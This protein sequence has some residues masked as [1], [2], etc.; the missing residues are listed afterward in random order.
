MHT[1][2]DFLDAKKNMNIVSQLNDFSA[3]RIAWID[4]LRGLALLMVIVANYFPLLG[5][6]HPLWLRIIVSYAIPVFL[7]L[8]AGMVI[9][10]A[11]KHDLNYYL[12][13]GIMIV[14]CAAIVDVFF[15]NIYPFASF[16]I[17]YI[18]GLS[19][20]IIYLTRTLNIRELAGIGFILVL[21]AWLTQLLFGYHSD[22]VE[23]YD[24]TL[25]ILQSAFIDGWYPIL[26][27]LGCAFFGAAFFKWLFESKVN[28]LSIGMLILSLAAI[29]IGFFFLFIPMNWLAKMTNSGIIESRLGYSE[30]FYP[31]TLAYMLS[32][33]GVVTALVW[34]T[35]RCDQYKMSRIICTFGR[36]PLLIYI[37]YFAL[38]TQAAVPLFEFFGQR[39]TDSVWVF[40]GIIFLTMMLLYGVCRL[41]DFIK[42]FRLLPSFVLHVFIGSQK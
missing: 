39:S 31:P 14:A 16:D 21:L 27:W 6:P 4:L 18:T 19:L 25:R 13:R 34:I 35:Q 40:A 10:N 3:P 26:P 37:L 38:Y 28:K 2:L 41:M 17:L 1:L 12:L 33:F 9:L 8:S 5:I 20:P 7:M 42:K 30:L 22:L 29:L 24:G 11:Q 32:A 36:Y 23:T 15:W